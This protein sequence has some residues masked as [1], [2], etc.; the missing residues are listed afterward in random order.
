MA[1][2]SNWKGCPAPQPVTLEGR[3]CVLEPFNVDKH[4]DSLYAAEVLTPD[5]EDRFRYLPQPLPKSLEDYKDWFTKAQENKNG[6]VYFSIIDK[7]TG[8]A[9]GRFGLINVSTPHGDAEFG[10]VVFGPAMRRTQIATEALFLTADY[11]FG[12]GY[13]RFV[14]K[15]N[16]LNDPSRRA[17]ARFGFTYEGLFRNHLVIK[18]KNRD[19]EW[20]SIIDSEW[21]AIKAKYEAW[22]SPENFD[23]EGKQKTKLEIA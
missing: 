12:L 17:A 8:K 7:R 4:V 10:H 14:W 18:G 15:L 5:A 9:E 13:R 1:D 19:T 3:Y 6:E 22:L 20:Y 21:P 16:S 11:L 2:L 23:A